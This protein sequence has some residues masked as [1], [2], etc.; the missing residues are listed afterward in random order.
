MDEHEDGKTFL[1]FIVDVACIVCVII[2]D[3]RESSQGYMDVGVD[4]GLAHAPVGLDQAIVE[5]VLLG[6]DGTFFSSVKV[7]GPGS[8]WLQLLKYT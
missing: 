8:D 6:T 2:A 1:V 4:T 7:V 5:F 3:P